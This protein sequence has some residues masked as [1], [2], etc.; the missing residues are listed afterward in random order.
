MYV[1]VKTLGDKANDGLDQVCTIL[2]CC[3][4]VSLATDFLDPDCVSP[5]AVLRT[6][7]VSILFTVIRLSFG[8]MRRILGYVAIVMVITWLVL[9]CQ[10]WWV[11]ESEPG[12]KNQPIPQCLLGE[13][14]AIAQ[15]ISEYRLAIAA[16]DFISQ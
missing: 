6:A 2:L 9:F 13:N 16:A 4:V 7:R 10:V 11:C 3:G 1:A 5:M 12:W 15:V 8:L 14:V